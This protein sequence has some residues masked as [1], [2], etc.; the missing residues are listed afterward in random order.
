[1]SG[2]VV[3]TDFEP[4]F[5]KYTLATGQYQSYITGAVR[6]VYYYSGAIATIVTGTI[7]LRPL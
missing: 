6:Y 7:V 3:P 5:T 1:M 2:I 4:A